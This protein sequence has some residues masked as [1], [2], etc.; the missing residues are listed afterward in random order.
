VPVYFVYG[1]QEMTIN[2]RERLTADLRKGGVT[3]LDGQ[4]VDVKIHDQTLS[5]LGLNDYK[6]GQGDWPTLY[7]S[8]KLINY[9]QQTSKF[10]LLLT[11]YPQYFDYY[12]KDYQY[13]DY[14]IDLILAGHA[15]GG[16]IRLPFLKGLFA[17]EQGFFPRY[18]S[19]LYQKNDVSMIVSRGLG[20]SGFPFRINNPPDVVVVNL[21]PQ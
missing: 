14:K 12:N 9:F 8:R 19:G 6:I 2:F 10:K 7:R 4:T 16:L 20:N 21:L 13:S 11:H 5:I 17:P 1:N 3:V 15:H 18:T